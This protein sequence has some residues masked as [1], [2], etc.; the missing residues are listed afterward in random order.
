MRNQFL[1]SI[2]CLCFV[3]T[4]AAQEVILNAWGQGPTPPSLE[5][6]T[7]ADSTQ[8]PA[9]LETLQ[10]RDCYYTTQLS[11]AWPGT[12]IEIQ[13]DSILALQDSLDEFSI[14]HTRQILEYYGFPGKSLVGEA[15][16]HT[17]VFILLNEMK[18]EEGKRYLPLLQAAV[19]ELELEPELLSLLIDSWQSA[20]H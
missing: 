15:N 2:A 18:P 6:F 19:Q 12:F 7:V 3:H 8:L 14:V 5:G 16:T 9:L 17:M 11:Y 10:Q 1:L 13:R 20:N 4:A